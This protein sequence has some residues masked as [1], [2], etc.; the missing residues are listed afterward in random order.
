MQFTKEELATIQQAQQQAVMQDPKVL[1]AQITGEVRKY[2]AELQDKTNQARVQGQ[3]ER[4]VA[5]IQSEVART[6]TTA[7]A[8]F[9]EL[10]L[11]KELALL[12]YANREK[13]SLDALKTQLAIALSGHDLQRE[14]ATLPS[15]KEIADAAKGDTAPEDAGMSKTA[16]GL[17]EYEPYGKAPDGMAAAL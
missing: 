11:R 4:D 17:P 9:A 10:Q 3:Y 13:I 15:V 14:L 2:V 1:V 12:E 16:P 8:K 7:Q 6:E 5:Y